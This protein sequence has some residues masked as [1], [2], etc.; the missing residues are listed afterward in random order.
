MEGY[1]RTPCVSPQAV[2]K[3]FLNSV[4]AISA[5]HF[6][7]RRTCLHCRCEPVLSSSAR[8]SEQRTT[9]AVDQA[10]HEVWQAVQE[11]A[12]RSVGAPLPR[13]QRAEAVR[14]EA[15]ERRR[16]PIRAVERGR[17]A[18]CV[19]LRGRGTARR[20]ADAPV[21]RATGRFERLLLGGTRP[22]PV[23]R[24]Q[25]ESTRCAHPRPTTPLRTTL[26]EGCTAQTG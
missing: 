13:L 3:R 12:A 14:Q 25:P 24:A 8:C 18:Q 15:G 4:I 10:A 11:R 21:R 26:F 17:Q 22:P 9:R 1:C 16:L 5:A 19:L 2:L 7:R 20:A 6:L 23:R